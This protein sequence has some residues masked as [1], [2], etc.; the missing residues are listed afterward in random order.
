MLCLNT[1]LNAGYRTTGSELPQFTSL[2]KMRCLLCYSN[3]DGLVFQKLCGYR[4]EGEYW[5]Y[6][7]IPFPSLVTLSN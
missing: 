3:A 5:E 7:N 2:N 1:M 4:H 6:S